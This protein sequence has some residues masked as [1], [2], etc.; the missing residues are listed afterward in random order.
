VDVLARS[1]MQ[2]AGRVWSSHR[3]NVGLGLLRVDICTSD[4]EARLGGLPLAA[5]N[6]NARA[7]KMPPAKCGGGW[8]LG[9]NVLPRRKELEA[10]VYMVRRCFTHVTCQ[11]CNLSSRAQ[12]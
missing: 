4:D 11:E 9:S 3:F 6:V 2:C 7:Q 1:R 8:L 12:Y 5:Q 10:V